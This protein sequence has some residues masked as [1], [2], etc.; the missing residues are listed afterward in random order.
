MDDLHAR[1]QT[2]RATLLPARIA[3]H[4]AGTVSLVLASIAMDRTLTALAG[5]RKATSDMILML[6]AVRTNL[7][8][9]C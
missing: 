1:E 4:I 7:A 5:P 2:L 9:A 8:L 3:Q 6:V